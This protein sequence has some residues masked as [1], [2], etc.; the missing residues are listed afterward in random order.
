[1]VGSGTGKFDQIREK[2]SDATGS[3][4]ATLHHT[5]ES[6][7]QNFSKNSAVGTGHHTAA[8]SSSVVCILPKSQAPHCVSHLGVKLHTKESK[9]KSLRVSGCFL[10]DNQEK[11]F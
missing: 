9:S 11:S 10:W 7:D 5:A 4:S 1:M 6:R 3:G 8:E 2:G